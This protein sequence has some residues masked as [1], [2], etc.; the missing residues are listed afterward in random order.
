MG[1]GWDRPRGTNIEFPFVLAAVATMSWNQAAELNGDSCLTL[2]QI[3]A[4]FGAPISEEQG[5]IASI[6]EPR[7]SAYL[8]ILQNAYLPI[9]AYLP[10]AHKGK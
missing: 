3:L 7:G 5:R 9:M 10:L 1:V 6:D 4:S 2:S 8:P